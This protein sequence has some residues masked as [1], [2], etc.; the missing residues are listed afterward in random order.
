M[1]GR[2]LHNLFGRSCGRELFGYAV[3]Y[4]VVVD[5][6]G[7]VNL[8]GLSF[9]VFA[10]DNLG[11]DDLLGNLRRYVVGRDDLLGRH[12]VGNLLCKPVIVEPA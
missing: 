2:G 6:G 12:A 8:Y 1:F 4:L 10:H 9:S 3:C 5:F 7:G 11:Y